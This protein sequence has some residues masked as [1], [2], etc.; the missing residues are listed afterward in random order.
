MENSLQN[1]RVSLAYVIIQCY[2]PPNTGTVKHPR[3]T[4]R[5]PVLDLPTM[6]GLKAELILVLVI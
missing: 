5:W 6:E 3:Q 4:A 2:P 1:Y